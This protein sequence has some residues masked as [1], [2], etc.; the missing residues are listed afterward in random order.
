MG[1]ICKF[2]SLC[3][4][5]RGTMAKEPYLIGSTIVMGICAIL[6]VIGPLIGTVLLLM[7]MDSAEAGPDTP[8]FVLILYLPYFLYIVPMIA[9]FS[10]AA[11]RLRDAGRSQAYLLV[12]PL[13]F[14]GLVALDMLLAWGI[15]MYVTSEPLSGDEGPGLFAGTMILAGAGLF[16]S[17]CLAELS[18]LLFG[19]FRRKEPIQD[20][21]VQAGE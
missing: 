5:F 3:F 6:F 2:F 8:A 14:A 7:L 10:L 4:S 20:E 13:V 15:L 9:Q 21:A 11:R 18:F 1:A 17:A 12:P 16:V 19:L